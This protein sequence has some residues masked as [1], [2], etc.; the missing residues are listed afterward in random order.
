MLTLLICNR[1]DIEMG[2]RQSLDARGVQQDHRLFKCA[3][4]E[5]WVSYL[6]PLDLR[7]EIITFMIDIYFYTIQKVR[8]V[9]V[10]EA[11]LK[12]PPLHST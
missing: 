8:H 11:V 12:R 4:S 1:S 7:I 2:H 10:Y 5:A 9:K 6:S 3:G